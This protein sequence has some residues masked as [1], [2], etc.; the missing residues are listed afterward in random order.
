MIAQPTRSVAIPINFIGI[1]LI[2]PHKSASMIVNIKNIRFKAVR[3]GGP[4]G[5]NV[6]R[7]STKVHAWV[8]VSDL[9]LTGDE[10]ARVRR[11]LAKYINAAD[12]IEVT[13]DGE[14]FQARN[15]EQAALRLNELVRGALIIPRRRIP[16]RPSRGSREARLAGKK[17]QSEKKRGRSRR[18]TI[19]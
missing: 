14:R 3:A 13:R 18:L 6:N 19:E 12:E 10:K 8:S 9:A 2:N 4:G 5:Q 16:T 17:L 7:R 1:N 15:K 11:R